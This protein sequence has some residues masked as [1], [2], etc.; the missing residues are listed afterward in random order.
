M[1]R[2][3]VMLFTVITLAWSASVA[4]ADPA[5]VTTSPVNGAVNVDP[6]SLDTIWVGFNDYDMD[7]SSFTGSNAG[8]VSVNNGA[9]YTVS[10]VDGSL[11]W[12][13][14]FI[15]ISLS[16][17][18]NYSTTYTVIIDYR[19]KNKEGERLGSSSASNYVFSFTT[20][21]KPS[22]DTTAP[23]VD[24]TFPV[25]SAVDVPITAAI[26]VTFDEV[27]KADTIN[28]TNFLINNGAVAGA[29]TLDASG[30][31]A[32][33]TPSANL[34]SFTTY[35]ATVTTG[36]RD[37]ADNALASNYSWNFRTMAL[38][39]VRPTVTVV[40]P[41][42][43]ATSVD[44]TTVIT[45]TFSEAMRD[46][47][48][49][50]ANVSV[51]G[52]VTGTVSYDPATWTLSFA[53]TAALA[54]STNYT[55]TISTGVTDLA[56][57]SLLTA[58]SWTFTTRAVTTPPPLND[59]CQVP[60]YVTST[61]N[62]VKPNVLLV[63]DNSGSMY[64][65]AY[66]NSGAGNNSYDTSYTPAKS[67]YGYFD[68]KKMYLYSGGA[69]VPDTAAST[70]TDT[71]KF[72]SGNFLNWLT[73]RRVDVVR[74]VLVG[75]KMTPRV[76]AGRYLYPAGS[77]D[78]DFY[79]SYNNVKYTVQ[80]GASTEVIKDTTNNVTYNLKIAI[81]DEGSNQDEGLVPKYANMINFGIMFYNE[82]YKYENSVNNVRDGGYVAADLGSTGS[83]LVTQIESTD[84]TTWT[85]LG[86]TLFEA[87]RYFQAGSSAYN[88]GT[89][90]GKD[91]INYACQKNFVLILT[92]GEST[93]DENIPGGSTNFSGKVTDS[94]FNVKTW[95]D[96]IATQEGYASQYSSSA[97]TSEGTY[98]L[99]GVAYWS[100]VTDMRSASLGDSDIPG[101]QNLTIYTVFA[102]DDSPVGRDLLKKTAK[103]GGFNDYD[104]TGKPDKVAKW[105]QD[106]NGIPDTYYEASDGAALAASLQKAFNDILARVSSGTAASILSNSEGSGANILQ[107]VFH[108]RKYFDAQTSADW[109]GEMHNMWYF[110]DPKIKNSSIR[111]DSDYIPGSPAP[112]HY[113]N[114]SKDKL[115]NFYFNTDQAKTM[116]KRYT[117]VRG[118][119][120]PDLDTNGDLKADS[121][122][123]YDEV[124]SDSVKSIWKAGKQLWSRTAAR[125][126]YTNLAGSLTSFTGLDTT[127]GN[128]QQLLQAANKTEADKIISY[129]AG[130]DQ[131]GYRNRT[132]NIGGVT[133]TWR[134]GDIVSSTPRLQSSVKQ[135]VYN[136]LSPKGY[137]DRS[138]GDDYTRKGYIYT[139]SY[140]NRG[141][142]YVGANDGMLHAFKLGL[143]DVTASGDRKGKL[144]GEDLGEEQW[145]FIPK[146][147][148]PY[149]R[150]NA[151]R[152]YNHI[153]YV[154]GT[155]VINDVSMG[156]PAGCTDNYWDCTRDVENG[157]N[158]RTVLVSS[159]G[160][161]GA[162]KIA[163]SGCKGTTCVETPI[164][165]PANAGEGV[166][167]SSYFALDITN[168]DSPSL[169][170]EFG[171][172]NLG[173]S[174]NGA[175]FVKISA[176]KADGVTPDLTKNGKWFAVLASGP[177]GPIDTALH[178]FKASSN[179]N[180]TIYVLNL[181]DGSIAATIDTLAD[182]TKLSN[183]FAGTITN[184]TVDTDRWNRNARGHYEDDALYIGY[185]Q[186]SGT[187][188]TGGVL[189]LMTGENLDPTT[190]KLSKVIDGVGPV[191]TNLT[192][193]Q[194]RQ[195]HN[196]WLYFG[197]G[198]YYYSQDDNDATR[199]IAAVKDPCYDSANDKLIPTCTTKKSLSD[200][201]NQST[202]R[203]AVTNDG[204]YINLAPVDATHS[205]GAER[206]IA[207][208]SALANGVVYYT[209]FAPTTDP[210]SFG[211]KSYMYGLDYDS[212][213]APACNQL[214]E[215]IALVQ[216]STG[217][218]QEIHLKDAIGCYNNKG[219]FVP[220]LPPTD[221]QV[222]PA[223]YTPPPGKSYSMVG[224]PPG[225]ASPIVSASGLVPAKRILHILEH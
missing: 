151:D 156:T 19:V 88:G 158:W 2:L 102:F 167:Y 85:P 224:K 200:L 39:S 26:T 50:S 71:T 6:T 70:V 43:G 104:S 66:K 171:K 7:K 205:F 196:L 40:S 177:T 178:R 91:P 192:R 114:L 191:T 165:D 86:E 162:S 30:K 110:V 58:K 199:L 153:Y 48:I 22:S 208:P 138:Y 11:P 64:E 113:L 218:F 175:A 41:I 33:F 188:W 32:T 169:L 82:G 217:A 219:E 55:V 127:D 29:V 133:G 184:A 51:S 49:T 53:P 42:A 220:P 172:P 111:E 83:N 207:D 144:S 204:W 28:S 103:Y 60:P 4:Q 193:L 47:T 125:N 14:D 15:K 203:S 79:K 131:S 225:D 150:Y 120:Q 173:F 92:D 195:K 23:V 56:G 97:N 186:L 17:D 96:S 72:L 89:Y 62:M 221:T 20:K 210:C 216:L 137:G 166:G 37:A 181:A 214:G 159:M 80:G 67:Y 215:G 9:T 189:R 36:V 174:T 3:L 63:V 123:P 154:D 12:N 182:G 176:K 13:G 155:T 141:M 107:A 202:S 76:G 1:R 209:T 124:D 170:W 223:G 206:M 183:A 160:L 132:V 163:G 35:T 24:S 44:T 143:L 222:N 190:W 135:N 149:L 168:P 57:N 201:T 52:G 108:P 10:K 211:G 148:L 179:Q 101:K 194:D 5:V 84:P 95:M 119:G 90:S 142:V 69:F 117:D 77:P 180:L 61:N 59:Y 31:V 34:S 157:S 78:R 187:D 81:G 25:S 213:N 93:K 146:N 130:T 198:R 65:F 122:T 38:D 75:G 197:S 94:S 18:L 87:T 115:I 46:T 152:D 140:T 126:I 112:P 68:D 116:V 147:A 8:R 21:A 105:D 73:M 74:K 100:H 121:Y 98:Y 128:I 164:T 212:G 161:G 118:D 99:E 109:I 45:A 136:M 129:I 185:S 106:G 139:S 145:S 54:N 134:L 27:M 16:K